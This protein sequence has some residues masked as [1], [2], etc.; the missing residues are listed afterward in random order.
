MRSC[1]QSGCPAHLSERHVR[2][3]Q[4]RPGSGAFQFGN[5]RLSPPPYRQ[6]NNGHIGE[7][8]GSIGG[9]RV[10]ARGRIRT[11]RARL[12]FS[13]TRRSR[14][15][16]RSAASTLRHNTHFASPH[17]KMHG[18]EARFASSDR[19]AD[20]IPLIDE[21]TR[22]VFC[23]SVGNPAGN[24]CD[25]EALA[26][27]SS[28]RGVPLPVDNTVRRPSFCASR[29]DDLIF[30]IVNDDSGAVGGVRWRGMVGLPSLHEDLL[31]ASEGKA[32]AT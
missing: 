1:D 7:A 24:I 9:R 8:R 2:I 27:V 15:E 22:E 26:E 25:V 5:T 23:E 6:S 20:I 12:C 16:H 32:R 21:A 14:R 30:Q 4:R 18:I 28:S 10:G 29:R 19:A 17:I 3:L 13:D 11:G 31:G